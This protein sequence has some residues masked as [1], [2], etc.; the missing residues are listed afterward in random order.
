MEIGRKIRDA[1]AAAGLTQEQAA[2]ELHVSRQT[3]SNWENGKTWPDIV[4]VVKMSDLYNISLD[5][6][7]K[8]DE[9]VSEYVSHLAES[10]DAAAG[11]KRLAETVL[12]CVYLG[13]WAF[14]LVMFWFFTGPTDAMGY[15]LLF[16]WTLLPV[17]TLVLSELIGQLDFWGK[18]KWLAPLFFGVMYMLA[19]YATFQCA[20][21]AATAAAVRHLNMPRLEMIPIAAAISLLGLA[22]GSGI[23]RRMKSKKGS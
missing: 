22:L 9:N 13:I 8:E 3:V 12:V 14:S 16:L 10:A 23:R 7:L 4:S 6:L 5:R 18:W 15:G 1:R 20:N 17:T 2:E 19:E 11:R 21:M